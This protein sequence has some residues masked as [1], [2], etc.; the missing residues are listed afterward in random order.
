MVVAVAD[1]PISQ[2]QWE[3]SVRII[4]SMFPPA[5]L[6]EDI[7]EPEDWPL[8]ISAEQKTNPRLTE[9]IGNIDLVPAE[10]RVRG[11]GASYLMAPFTHSTV[12]RP[13][14][15]SDG[16]QG[17]LYIARDFETAVCETAYHHARFMAATNE[18]PSW[19][20]RFRELLI[21][22]IAELHDIRGNA[23]DLRELLDPDDYT[24]SQQFGA[25]LLTIGSEGIA[26]PSVRGEGDCAGLFYPDLAHN[27]A[28][29]R[30]LEFHWDGTR[31]DLVRNAA[32]GDVFRIV[33]QVPRQEW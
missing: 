6:F 27:P 24:K 19:G 10:R 18:A 28:Q 1:V 32:T 29:G 3:H 12:D 20:S 11:P 4:R 26:Y 14:R 31:V 22:V 25:S 5:D 16:R 15:F 9:T 33:D 23:P 2:I 7:A 17:V 13:S 30:H 21:D 8:L